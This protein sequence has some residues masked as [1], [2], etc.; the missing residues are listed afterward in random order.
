MTSIARQAEPVPVRSGTLATLATAFAVG[1]IAALAALHVVSPEF[2]P[3]WRVVSEYALGDHGWLL[4][5]M[6]LCWALAS[7]ALAGAIWPLVRTRAARVGVV[8]LIVSGFG[9]VLAAWFDVRTPGMHGLAALVGIPTVPIAA[10]LLTYS[11]DFGATPGRAM[12]RITAHLTWIALLLMTIAMVV[13]MSTFPPD[14]VGRAGE[15]PAV[16]P[17]GVIAFNGWANRM[18][19]VVDALWIVACARRVAR[20]NGAEATAGS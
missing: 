12:L 4:S 13:L 19:V 6:F 9:E 5:T 8:F 7:W 15:A 10:L 1:A 14:A 11:I 3:S 2:D 20:L 17:D 18:L 16:L